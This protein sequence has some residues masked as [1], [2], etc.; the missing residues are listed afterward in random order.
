MRKLICGCACV[1]ISM[2]A[3]AS[4]SNSDMNK[5]EN[6]LDMGGDLYM[7]S[8]MQSWSDWRANSLE[9]ISSEMKMIAMET[10]QVNIQMALNLASLTLEELY[11][12]SG[13]EEIT[14]V[15][16]SSKYVDSFG[17]EK[18]FRIKQKHTRS[19]TDATSSIY[20][21]FVSGKKYSLSHIAD[22]PIE[23]DLFGLYDIDG[24]I[25][26]SQINSLTLA[27]MLMVTADSAISDMAGCSIGDII[28]SLSGEFCVKM[29]GNSKYFSFPDNSGK[30]WLALVNIVNS[31]SLSSLTIAGDKLSC[32]TISSDT[33]NFT[34]TTKDNI[35]EL[36]VV[37]GEDTPLSGKTLGESEK[38][39]KMATHLEGVDSGSCIVYSSGNSELS[40]STMLLLADFTKD[41]NSVIYISTTPLSLSYKILSELPTIASAGFWAYFA[42]ADFLIPPH[43][44]VDGQRIII[45]TEE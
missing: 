36:T 42:T 17:D 30:L 16:A 29:T 34:A 26:F 20:D 18:L 15:G 10:P 24:E 11:D 3:N 35:V 39:Q 21:A 27:P 33:F 44:D 8:D 25:L 43:I 23:T 32:I 22:L 14:A 19:S 38:F 9:M 4:D 7:V 6:Y 40:P 37:V 45:K 12:I 13:I 31:P 28:S 41:Y 2:L 5:V 1:L